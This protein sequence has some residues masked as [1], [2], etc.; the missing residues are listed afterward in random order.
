MSPASWRWTHVLLLW[1]SVLLVGLVLTWLEGRRMRGFWLL[2]Y[3]GNL[4][5]LGS[6][7]RGAL[8]TV[9]LLATGWLLLPAIALALTLWWAALRWIG[10]LSRPSI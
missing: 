10:G 7:V 6:F 8:S 2:P 5:A 3:P 4:R 9:P 1:G